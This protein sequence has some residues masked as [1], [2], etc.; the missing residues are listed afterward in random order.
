MQLHGNSTKMAFDCFQYLY[1]HKAALSENPI[2]ACHSFIVLA[3]EIILL[4]GYLNV[5]T[6]V[7]VDRGS[8]IS[9]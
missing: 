2:S 4:L 3:L 7:N 6:F 5:M 9:F 8:G 1:C